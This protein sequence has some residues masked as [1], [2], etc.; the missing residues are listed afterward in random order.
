MATLRIETGKR[1][2][3]KALTYRILIVC[4]DLVTIYLMTGS[5]KLAIG[6]TVISNLVTT[7]GYFLHERLWARIRW[8][9][10]PVS[11]APS[12]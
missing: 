8:G 2:A 10:T 7:V 12:E 4:T 6:F 9:L 11:D 5:T 3:V 1:S